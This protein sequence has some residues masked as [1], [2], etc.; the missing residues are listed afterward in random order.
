MNEICL[1]LEELMKEYKNF[2]SQAYNDPQIFENFK[3]NRI[4][5]HVLEHA[6]YEEG[7]EYLKLITKQTPEIV[8]EIFKIKRNDIIGNA[9]LSEY[10]VVGKISSS[11]L[12]YAAVLSNL[13]HIFKRKKWGK[14]AEIGVGYGGQFLINDAFLEFSD[15]IMFDLHEVRSFTKKYLENHIANNSYSFS[16]LNEFKKGF[17]FDLVISNYAF[18]ELPKKLQLKYI[19]KVVGNSKNGYMTMNSGASESVLQGDYLSINELK[20]KIKNLKIIDE[21]P[22]TKSGNYIIVWGEVFN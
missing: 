21:I 13:I 8:D 6:S 18:S 22:K 11:T 7:G 2:V 16:S 9:T 4:Y 14:I 17:K 15:Y 19:E 5:R 1:T 12:R 3:Q 10:P 20:N